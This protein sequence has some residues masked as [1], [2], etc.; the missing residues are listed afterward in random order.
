MGNFTKKLEEKINARTP[1]DLN[2]VFL[3]HL[4]LFLGVKVEIFFLC[5][6]KYESIIKLIFYTYCKLVIGSIGKADESL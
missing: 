6:V 4:L 5:R 3:T 1:V 2:R